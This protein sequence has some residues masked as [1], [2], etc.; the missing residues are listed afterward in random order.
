M[1][2]IQTYTTHTTK[3]ESKSMN[4][5]PNTFMYF[6]ILDQALLCM[7][8]VVD[9]PSS[10]I[11]TWG[12]DVRLV[13]FILSAIPRTVLALWIS[14]LCSRQ[15]ARRAAPQ[16]HWCTHV[17]HALHIQPM[18]LGMSY[19]WVGSTAPVEPVVS[20][21]KHHSISVLILKH[22]FQPCTSML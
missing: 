12:E 11:T 13:S 20:R 22:F 7:A 3:Q 19:K 15:L 8:N 21:C 10:L 9:P 2:D 18:I 1:R 5:R 17:W 6:A 16:I 14:Y 4:T